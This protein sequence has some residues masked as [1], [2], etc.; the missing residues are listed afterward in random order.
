MYNVMLLDRDIYM[1]TYTWTYFFLYSSRQDI[2]LYKY[3]V[4]KNGSAKK[5]GKQESRNNTVHVCNIHPFAFFSGKCFYDKHVDTCCIHVQYYT[6]SLACQL[7]SF[8]YDS[9]K[10]IPLQLC[11]IMCT[12][13]TA[14]KMN[15]IR[16]QGLRDTPLTSQFHHR[17]I[18]YRCHD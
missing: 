9:R 5:V 10:C 6:Y 11:I 2:V 15:T 7:F 14:L 16:K 8:H 12:N 3:K 17:N 1:H 18:E 13:I 4:S